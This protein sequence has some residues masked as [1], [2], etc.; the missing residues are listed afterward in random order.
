MLYG[1]I[2]AGGT[3]F[4]C[5]VGNEKYE[6]IDKISIET[7]HPEETFEQVINFFNKYSDE[8]TSIGI[9]SFGPINNDMN[10]SKY[11]YI[12]NTP[13]L[14]WKDFDFLGTL[15][16]SF[17][18]PMYWTTDVNAS[19][20]GEYHFG[21]GKDL[22]SIVYITIG[23]G[24][25][26]GAIQNGEYIGGASHPEM[27]HM[28]VHPYDDKAEKGICPY[29]DFCLEGLACGPAIEHRTGVKGKD[30][31]SDSKEWDIEAYYIAQAVYNITY[32]LRPER[33]ILGGGV[34]HKEMLLEK[35]QL[36]Y[37]ELAGDYLEIDDIKK[38]IV[39]PELG[40]EAA[41]KGCYQ[42]AERAISMK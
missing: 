21:S 37:Q 15:Q 22:T 42:L 20:N 32:I 25:G 30:L 17:N 1:A 26:G 4:V 2:E 27:G 3:K 7:S 31:D 36:K 23:T 13:K 28:I 29:H 19:A 8:M 34:M 39:L 35:V 40:D 12:T 10:S 14:L 6:T 9:G 33:V 38:Y 5:A 16:S 11:G 24:V 41:I 18:I